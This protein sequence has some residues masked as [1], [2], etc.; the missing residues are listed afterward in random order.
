MEKN[1][2]RRGI[3]FH[4]SSLRGENVRYLAERCEWEGSGTLFLEKGGVW[5]TK[6]IVLMSFTRGKMGC[7][8]PRNLLAGKE[9][10]RDLVTNNPA[11]GEERNH[12]YLSIGSRYVPEA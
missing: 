6:K 11:G 4:S 10:R 1:K 2:H 8:R 7:R 5:D 12:G 9:W 3:F